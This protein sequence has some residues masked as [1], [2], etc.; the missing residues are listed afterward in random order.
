MMR[1]RQVLFGVC[2]AIPLAAPDVARAEDI[3]EIR[4]SEVLEVAIRQSPTLASARIDSAVAEAQVV[5]SLGIEDLLLRAS[6]S[7]FRQSRES[8]EGDI[9][10][11]NSTSRQ[12]GLVSISKLLPTGGTISLHAETGR[13]QSDYALAGNVIGYSSE[14]SLRLTQPILRGRG[15]DVTRAQQRQAKHELSAVELDLAA[16]TRDEVRAIIDAYWELVWA[17]KDLEIR[18][19]ALGLAVERRRLTES[20]IKLGSSAA[21]A[22]LEVDQVMATNEEEILLAEQRV[23]ER[24]LDVRRLAG[25]EIGPQDLGLVPNEE[26]NVAPETFQLKAVVAKALEVSPELAALA[27][28]GAGSTITIEV[29]SNSLLPQLDLEAAAGPLGNDRT[30]GASLGDVAMFKGYFISAGLNYQQTISQHQSRGQ[31]LEARAQARRIQIGERDVRA[32]VAVAAARA[33]QSAE[34][35]S[36]RMALSQRAMNL[37]EKNIEAERRRFELGKATNFDVLQRQ[38]EQ[39]Q[40]RLRYARAAVDYL[41]ATI[42]IK[43]LNGELLEQYGIK[44]D[45]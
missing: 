32:Q 37:S 21:T 22:L 28:R 38:E 36:K 3:D 19:S 14:L 13:Q 24:S 45:H 9:I 5:Q 10:G 18:R 34:I 43:A 8:V 35:A 40:A 42:A 23:I 2:L 15:E 17:H 33:V 7:Y 39:K 12:S 16:R 11:T 29:A 6:G 25:L 31:Q 1:L 4:L 30:L 41:R 44:L 20:A 27:Q 26:L